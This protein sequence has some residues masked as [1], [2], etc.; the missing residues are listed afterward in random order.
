MF[1]IRTLTGTAAQATKPRDATSPSRTQRTTDDCTRQWGREP[2]DRVFGRSGPT[3]QTR[4]E[5]R[6]GRLSGGALEYYDFFIYATAASLIFS[7]IFFPPG[8]ET[9]AMLV[10]FATLGVAYVA[11]RS[12]PSSS[13][14]S[15]TRSAARTPSS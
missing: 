13:V 4:Q 12:A 1:T 8:D 6:A 14:T 2:G 11:G 5:G 3:P 10:S 15:V 9:A 7:K